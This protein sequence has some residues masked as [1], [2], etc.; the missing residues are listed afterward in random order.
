M[1]PTGR[2]MEKSRENVACHAYR[3]AAP[4]I[5]RACCQDWCGWPQLGHHGLPGPLPS[6]A[7]SEP[8]SDVACNLL[9]SH[10]RP[11]IHLPPPLPPCLALPFLSIP[12]LSFVSS[13]SVA[14]VDLRAEAAEVM[15]VTTFFNAAK[16]ARQPVRI[17][18]VGFR[19]K[20]VDRQI[21]YSYSSGFTGHTAAYGQ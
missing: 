5:R 17:W 15:P 20:G 14:K 9:L 12:F 6:G 1:R 19:G 4:R 10:T 11:S 18:G 7:G 21:R 8:A 13:V 16:Q 2:G 3:S